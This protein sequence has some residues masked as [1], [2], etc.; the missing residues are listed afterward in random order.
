MLISMF[1]PALQPTVTN[2]CPS[3]V[4]YNPL[5]VVWLCC[6]WMTANKGSFGLAP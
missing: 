3:F 2:P 6:Y 4:D 5:Y 1:S